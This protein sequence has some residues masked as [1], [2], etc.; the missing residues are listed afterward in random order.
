IV[1]TK[2]ALVAAW[3]GGTREGHRDVGIWLS[4][5]VDKHWTASVLVADGVVSTEKRHPCWN[6]VLFEPDGGPLMLFYKVG[7]TPRQWWGMLMRSEDDGKRWSKPERLP[8]GIWGPSKNKPIQLTGGM[9][10]CPTTIVC[11]TSSE[12]SG[13]EVHLQLTSD[14]GQTWESVG[15]VNDREQFEA[16]QPAILKHA[17]SR[18]QILCRSRQGCITQSWSSDGGKTWSEMVRTILPNP[19]SGI[20]AVTLKDGSQ[21]L[22]YNHTTM[23][24][25][26]RNGPRSPLNVAVSHDGKNWRAA[27][28]LE[29]E[30]GR[31]SYPAV[32]QTSDGMVHATYTYQRR[33]IKHV[34]LDPSKLE[35]RPM[36]VGRWPSEPAK[37]K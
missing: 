1:E 35:L 37:R 13:W 18:L 32:I 17:D 11:P 19:N 6:P 36:P 24:T 29:N 21:L 30:P 33:T 10:L 16:I 14:L 25:E 4:R 15:P 28:V 8:E 12:V 20:D 34:V 9:I 22:V 2:S 7:P 5:R 23:T 3:F 31:F 27:L 26:G